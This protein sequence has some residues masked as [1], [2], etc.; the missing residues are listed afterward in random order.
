MVQLAQADLN[1]ELSV[2]RRVF[3][4][5]LC[6]LVGEHLTHLPLLF[7][8]FSNCLAPGGRLVF[9]VFHPEM[10]AAGIEAHFE[11]DGV[12]YRLGAFRY[13]VDDYLN[14]IDAVGFRNLKR[15]E[16]CGDEALVKEIPRAVKYLNRRLL[17]VIHAH[18]S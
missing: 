5:V 11:E 4:A 1:N 9:S 3:K 14:L 6:A 8:S 15:E 12:E 10:A 16:F 13:T 17:L 2:R 7:R 18:R